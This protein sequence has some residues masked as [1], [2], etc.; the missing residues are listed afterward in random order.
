MALQHSFSFRGLS[1][2]T[3]Y[4]RITEVVQ[5]RSRNRNYVHVAVYA[6]AAASAE[7]EPLDYLVTDTEYDNAMTVASA[8]TLL[9]TLPEYAGAVDV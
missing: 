8:Y 6:S 3:A 4:F 5:S 9:K 1:T 2:T 7:Q